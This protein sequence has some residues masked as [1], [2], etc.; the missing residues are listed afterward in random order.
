MKASG[1]DASTSRNL[2]AAALAHAMAGDLAACVRICME[3]IGDRLRARALASEDNHIAY[4]LAE[5]LARLGRP[6]ASLS[7][8]GQVTPIDINAGRQALMTIGV[9]FNSNLGGRALAEAAAQPDDAYYA[10][11]SARMLLELHAACGEIDGYFRRIDIARLAREQPSVCARAYFWWP[12]AAS[13]TNAAYREALVAF[14]RDEQ[15]RLG[16]PA[17]GEVAATRP[18]DRSDGRMHIGY[19]TSFL[20]SS[21]FQAAVQPIIAR[22]DRTRCRVTVVSIDDSGAAAPGLPP[23]IAL[24]RLNATDPMPLAQHLA[25]LGLDVLVDVV[26]FG[27]LHQSVFRAFYWKPAPVIAT[28]LNATGTSGHPCIDFI[29]ADAALIPPGWEAHFTEK[30]ARRPTVAACYVPAAPLPRPA[31]L[32][33]EGRIRFGNSANHHKVTPESIGLWAGVLRALPDSD[34][35]LRSPLLVDASM[36]ERAHR[37]FEHHGVARDRVILEATRGFDSYIRSYHDVS[38]ILGTFPAHGGLTI[39]E[40]LW[41]GVP[42]VCLSGPTYMSRVGADVLAPLGLADLC[43]DS[44]EGFVDIAV[45]LAGDR[46]RLGEMRVGLRQDL[47]AGLGFAPATMAREAEDLFAAMLQARI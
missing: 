25:A 46:K 36:R 12:Y 28:W 23:D 39:M 5:C 35:A 42:T 45:R 41:M 38:V 27:D 43:P 21:S 34:F 37:L 13:M 14:H 16:A 1:A 17:H 44:A 19:L 18:P 30:V 47:D 7:V 15:R 8:L 3:A 24:V 40:A 6:S 31:P 4:L 32:P 33:A 11:G 10:P 9:I 20:G 26:S 22:H 2:H 29:I